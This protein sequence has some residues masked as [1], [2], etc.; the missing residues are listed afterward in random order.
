M[1]NEQKLDDILL[2]LGHD[3][4]NLGT[5]YI[6]QAVKDYRP[7]IAMTKELYPGLARAVGSSPARV[8]RMMRHSIEKA[9][10][11]NDFQGQLKYFG[12]SVD[13]DRGRPTVGE[14]VARLARICDEGIKP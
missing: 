13:P 2:E 4:F 1:I 9:W 3:D 8:E 5:A 10:A 11:R 7:G 14:Y 12:W 6:R